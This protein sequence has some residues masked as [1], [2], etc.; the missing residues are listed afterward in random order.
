MRKVTQKE[1]K[2]QQLHYLMLLISLL[3]SE[4]S[5]GDFAWVSVI[6]WGHLSTKAT[7]WMP[8]MHSFFFSSVID[9]ISIIFFI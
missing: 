4:M 3:P 7:E 9:E 6:L 1:K 2:T 8:F 5:L